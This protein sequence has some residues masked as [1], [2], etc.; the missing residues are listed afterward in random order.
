MKH[1][2]GPWER[3]PN[4]TPL[5]HILVRGQGGC[6]VAR[7][8]RGGRNQEELEANANLITAGPELLEVARL[9]AQDKWPRRHRARMGMLAEA[10]IAKAEGRA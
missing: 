3:D 10:A 4:R 8:E 2:P 7:V 1:T 6:A 9:A 5:G